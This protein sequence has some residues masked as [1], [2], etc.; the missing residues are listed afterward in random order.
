[1]FLSG[2]PWTRAAEQL[3]PDK[4][5][6]D[7]GFLEHY[8][9]ERWEVSVSHVYSVTYSVTYLAMFEMASFL[10]LLPYTIGIWGINFLHPVVWCF[11]FNVDP[12]VT[13]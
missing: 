10:I 5:S 7:L 1:M 4:H 2:S 13:V 3:A 12:L 9:M 8:A 11:E 6:R